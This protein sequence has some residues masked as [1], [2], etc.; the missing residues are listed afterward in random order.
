MKMIMKKT[1][2]QALFWG[3]KKIREKNGK[4]EKPKAKTEKKSKGKTTKNER[5]NQN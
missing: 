2:Q 1:C 3:F 4:K 5:G